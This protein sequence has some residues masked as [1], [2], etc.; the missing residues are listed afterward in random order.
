MYVFKVTIM[1]KFASV[2]MWGKVSINNEEICLYLII[3]MFHA[4]LREC[5]V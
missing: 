5:G 4:G 3:F 1:P 2:C